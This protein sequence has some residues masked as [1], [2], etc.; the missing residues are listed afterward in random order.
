MWTS[1]AGGSRK[2][3]AATRRSTNRSCTSAVLPPAPSFAHLNPNGSRFSDGSYGV[4]Y[5]ARELSTAIA[6]TVFH[7]G[8]FYAATADPP[9][10]EAMRVLIGRLDARFH[11][12]RGGARWAPVLDS[13]SYA[14]SRALGRRL[15]GEGSNGVVYP[16]VR[17]RGGQCV[18]AF[19]PKAVGPPVQARHLQYFW[20]GGRI[21]RYFD[22]A[23]DR[24]VALEAQG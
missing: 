3:T 15:R 7:L 4:Y 5:A 9:H 8:R 17:R 18:G 12:L 14:A 22:Y 6:E 13:A 2:R 20:D 11:D 19:R 1:K 21:S 24:W 10:G 16:S 23:E